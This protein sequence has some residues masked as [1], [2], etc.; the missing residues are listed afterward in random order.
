M[1]LSKNRAIKRATFE[2]GGYAAIGDRVK[3]I[4]IIGGE[5]KYE[6]II[7]GVQDVERR[8]NLLTVTYK[9][10]AEPKDLSEYAEK[11]KQDRNFFTNK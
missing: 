6:V 8:G 7:D 5:G 4:A 10:I 11:R 9:Y 1:L 3:L 2:C